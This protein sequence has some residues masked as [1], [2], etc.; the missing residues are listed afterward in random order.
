MPGRLETEVGVGATL[1]T[2][3]YLTH[4][5]AEFWD[6]P[7]AFRP[8]RFLG[9]RAAHRH[10]Y[11]Y[12]PFGG[13]PHQCVGRH[14][15]QAEAQLIAASP[16]TRFRP[17]LSREGVPALRVAATLLPDEPVRMMLAPVEHQRAA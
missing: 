1:L 13:G 15:F 12:F 14:V 2:S 16:L 9:Q 6:E 11:A 5:M 10:R 4:H 17:S 7:D 8:E 3:P